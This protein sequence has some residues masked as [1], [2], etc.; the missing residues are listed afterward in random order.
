MTSRALALTAALI[1]CFL[2][3]GL[4]AQE[5][6][7]K[8]PLLSTFHLYLERGYPRMRGGTKDVVPVLYAFDGTPE[9]RATLAEILKNGYPEAGLNAERAIALQ[10]QFDEKLKYY[11]DAKM[12]SVNYRS[13][14]ASVTGV[15]EVKDGKKWIMNAKI[16]PEKND[17]RPSFKYPPD[18][19]LKPNKPFVMP[20]EEPIVLKIDDKLSL[21]CMPMPPGTFVMGSPFYQAPRYQDEHPHEV[22]LTKLFYISEIPIT[23]EI[24]EA[25]MGAEKNV[26]VRRNPQY[27]VEFAPFPD[28]RKF[29]R[30]LSERN[31][32]T[33]RLP[34]G[35]EM[36]YAARLGTSNPNFKARYKCPDQWSYVGCHERYGKVAPVKTKKPNAWGLYDV[37][38]VGETAVSDFKAYNRP[39]KQVDP[40]GEPLKSSWVI[41]CESSLKPQKPVENMLMKRRLPAVHRAVNGGGS[42]ARPGYHTRYTEDGLDGGNGKYVVTIFRIAVEAK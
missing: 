38:C 10:Q 24:W 29:C 15:L 39:D 1:V 37:F 23:Q 30:V 9:V 26:S 31:G 42:D 4:Y 3:G 16:T 11:L 12:R 21:K 19:F 13:R 18:C 28:I 5:V 32:R 20:R 2:C 22:V 36:E 35:A 8:G 33:V 25:V 27:A 17:D 40:K 41:A 34:T 6:T 14:L 7:L